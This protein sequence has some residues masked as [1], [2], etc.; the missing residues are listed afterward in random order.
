MRLQADVDLPTGKLRL[1]REALLTL[2]ALSD[3]V[4]A[5]KA[6]PEAVETLRVA[7]LIEEAKLSEHISF[8]ADAIRAPLLNLELE[9]L[10]PESPVVC[11][12]WIDGNVAVLAVPAADGLDDVKVAPTAHLIAR[13]GAFLGLGP[14]P[15]QPVGQQLD[16]SATRLHWRVTIAWAHGGSCLEVIDASENGLWRIGR[17]TDGSITETVPAS[18]TD[19]WRWLTDLVPSDSE[20]GP[21][22]EGTGS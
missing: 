4:T 21:P 15:R 16:P 8:V 3:P 20:L 9:L 2:A 10:G 14:R 22:G 1:S 12:G 13:L 5:P 17:D 18:S 7:G 19:V 6:D 11:P